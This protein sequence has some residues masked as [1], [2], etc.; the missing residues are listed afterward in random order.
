MKKAVQTTVKWQFPT[1][2][3]AGYPDCRIFVQGKDN[4][5]WVLGSIEITSEL[6]QHPAGRCVSVVVNVA[7][8]QHVEA[9]THEILRTEWEGLTDEVQHRNQ[10]EFGYLKLTSSMFDGVVGH[11]GRAYSIQ[12]KLLPNEE[13]LDGAVRIGVEILTKSGAVGRYEHFR[14][15]WMLGNFEVTQKT[16]VHLKNS[17]VLGWCIGDWQPIERYLCYKHGLQE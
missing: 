9:R 1:E 17:G 3:K 4:K 6:Y 13:F 11:D 8:P 14:T 16:F 2:A 15:K 12:W 10:K 7:N 5:E